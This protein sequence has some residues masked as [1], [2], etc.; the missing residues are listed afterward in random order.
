MSIEFL[1]GSALA[2]MA[3]TAF[4]TVI[5]IIWDDKRRSDLGH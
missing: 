1:F 5:W 3:L 4:G 2:A